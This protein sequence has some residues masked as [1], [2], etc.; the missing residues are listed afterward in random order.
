[1]GQAGIGPAQMSRSPPLSVL[2]SIFWVSVFRYRRIFFCLCFLFDFAFEI[3]FKTRLKEKTKK[4]KAQ[5][6]MN[7]MPNP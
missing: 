1:M 5:V 6:W 7:T 4:K 3:Q 2:K